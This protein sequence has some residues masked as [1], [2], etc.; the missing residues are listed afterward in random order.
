MNRGLFGDVVVLETSVVNQF[1]SREDKSLLICW[2]SLAIL[3]LCSNVLDGV[4]GF[5]VQS[6][7]F[8]SEAPKG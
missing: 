4:G 7:S 5:H 1:F 8:S 2:N 6:D 3:D